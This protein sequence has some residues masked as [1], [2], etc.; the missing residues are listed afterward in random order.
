MDAVKFLKEKQ[1]MCDYIFQKYGNCLKCKLY[2]D[3]THHVD[4]SCDE[5]IY[6]YPKQSIEITEE[7]RKLHPLRTI[8]D[9][10][11]EKYPNA[12]LDEEGGLPNIC[13]TDLGF[14]KHK[15]CANSL[16]G[17]ACRECWSI[18]IDEV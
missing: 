1:R 12:P 10:F 2:K 18:P 11:K 7:W 6:K 9:D 17:E 5:Y 14:E 13:P 16:G 4:L 15:E 8:L 3:N